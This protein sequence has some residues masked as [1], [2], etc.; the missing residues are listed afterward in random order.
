MTAEEGAERAKSKPRHR[1]SEIDAAGRTATCVVC[2]PTE[3]RIRNNGQSHEC[4]TVRKANR[5]TGTREG[6]RRYHLKTYGLTLD[7]YEEMY[8]AVGGA[9]EIC[10]ISFP[11]L[12]IDH[13]H[14]TGTVRGLLCLH[15]NSGL[16]YFA[17]DQARLTAASD[18]LARP[19]LRP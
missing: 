17:D 12:F 11:T 13:D 18:Y 10:G 8:A 3:I 5:G 1:L 16:G 4:M 2:G 15:C 14:G 7:Q 19:G 9:C 6:R